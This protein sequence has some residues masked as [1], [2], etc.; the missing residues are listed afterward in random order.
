MEQFDW[1]ELFFSLVLLFI[2]FSLLY[3]QM[4]SNNQLRG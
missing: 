1:F 2:I 4:Q 3:L